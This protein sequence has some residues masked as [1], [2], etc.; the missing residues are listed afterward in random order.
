MNVETEQE[1]MSGT[2]LLQEGVLRNTAE[3]L[4]S[5][6]RKL[7]T[8]HRLNK[9]KKDWDE[10]GHPF[11]FSFKQAVPNLS[12]FWPFVLNSCDPTSQSANV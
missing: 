6:S 5:V 2:R 10:I 1:M 7:V 4:S 9:L 3:S 11:S 12:D 8:Y